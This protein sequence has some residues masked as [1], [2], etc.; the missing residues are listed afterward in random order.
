MTVSPNDQHRTDPSGVLNLLDDLIAKARA[1]GADAADAVL[2]D[3]AS[4]SLAHRLG[5]TEKLERSESGDLGLRVFVGKRQAIV[6]STDRSGKAL[7]ELVERAIAM[8]RVVPEDGF[9]GIADPEQLARSW[10]DLDICDDEEPSAE[11]LIERARIAEEAALAVPGVTNSEGGDAGWSRSTIAIAAS[12]G[13]AGTYGVSRQSL[14]AS[15]LAGTG[16]GMERDYDYDSKVYGTDLRDAAEIGREA[17]ERAVRRLNP[18][19]VKSC[20]VPVVFDPRVS[21]GLL[22]H[23][24][25]A[26]SGPSIA[27]G[28]SFLKDKMGQQIFAPSITIIDDPHVKRGLRS[29]PFD[30]EGVEVSR[31]T[32]IEDG[33]L[34]TWLLDLRSARQLGLTT[35]GHAA[36]GTSGPPGPAP[37][38]VYMAAGK[39]SRADILAEIKDGFYVT[40]LMGMGV[41]GV[42]G[43][44]SRGAGGFWIENGQITYPVNEITIAGNLKDMFLNM[45]AADDLELRFGMDAPTVRIDGMTIAGM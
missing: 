2:F 21:R 14:S 6:S 3:S 23:L 40:D 26:I 4:V 8:A 24:T 20:K 31:R 30:A 9:A 35:T 19:R 12:N 5:K 44:Y 22:G 7:D 27:R 11:T 39:R 36:R 13:F 28:T 15:V 34:T 41:N 33:V 25:G 16:T 45:E 18:R 42:T 32:L 43:D 38:N 1:A 10:P 17:G 29:R 37:A